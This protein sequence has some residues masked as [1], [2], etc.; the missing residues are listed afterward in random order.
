[1]KSKKIFKLLVITLGI[2]I[3]C[4][5]LA[6]GFFFTDPYKRGQDGLYDLFFRVSNRQD[7]TKTSQA[8]IIAI[9]DNSLIQ[10]FEKNGENWPWPRSY[11][12]L[13]CDYL[14]KDGAK[15][16][17]LDIIYSSPD[18]ERVSGSGVQNDF[19]FYGAMK[20]HNK[21]IIPLNIDNRF[22]KRYSPEY[23]G[24]AELEELLGRMGDD[25]RTSILN[26]YNLEAG[27]GYYELDYNLSQQDKEHIS[28]I[29]KRYNFGP[30]ILEVKGGGELKNVADFRYIHP[31]YSLFTLDNNKFGYV[32]IASEVDG[33]IRNYKPLVRVDESYVPSVALAA[34][35]ISD[36]ERLPDG[37][38][39][40][41]RG[42]FTL[43]WYGPGGINTDESGVIIGKPTFDYYSAWYIFLNARA[44]LRGQE[45]DLPEGT[46]KNR[47]VFIGASAR[48]LL[49]QKNTPF[50]IGGNAY[51]GVEIH[52]TAYLN[53]LN[54]D[55]LK[56]I[57]PTIEFLVYILIVF[58]ITFIGV[59]AKS[60]IRYTIFAFLAFI[61]ILVIQVVSF[62]YLDVVS[63][64]FLYFTFSLLA[65]IATVIAN[66]ITIGQNRNRIR[67]AFGTYV[68]PDILKSITESDE[69]LSTTGKKLEATAL[70]I[71]IA[72]FTT[73]SEK[74]SPERVVEVLNIYL[75]RFSEAIMENKGFIN[76]FLGD[77]LM[78]LF[79]APK[80]IDKHADEA[81]QSALECIRI[82][83]ELNPQYGLDIR[84]GV[85]SGDMI[86]GNMGGT[87]KLE[88][89]AIGDNVNLS[90]RLEGANKFFK[91]KIL[92]GENTHS[93]MTE[94]D[95]VYYLGK[96][97]FKGKDIPIGVYY[98]VNAPKELKEGFEKLIR[99]FEDGDE[100]G[101][102]RMLD[103]FAEKG[104]GFGPA[105]Y[106]RN[107]Y[108]N[109]RDKFGK[110]I[111][112]T[113][114]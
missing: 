45:T 28:E 88:P 15:A 31:P 55:W 8:A 102:I 59:R 5:T 63:H 113:E 20:R 110:P 10:A 22:E 77:G 112:L 89:T 25:E 94:R 40:D 114:K 109:N 24:Q 80:D 72:G 34:Y 106:Y 98:Y 61:V 52:A 32:D 54:R 39:L 96:F 101:F 65:F 87:K 107:Y 3:L 6:I 12:G 99:Y 57:P 18:I 79:S 29:F 70:F 97:S 83:E 30:S 26:S 93:L 7:S 53:L 37:L 85:N 43:N 14:I 60:F 64:I 4:F 1:M 78:A 47:V 38:K 71:D 48:G 23:L 16:V 9:D 46:F 81:I 105:E 90:S 56:H 75:Q 74:N 27:K 17:V 92:L 82:N 35:L 73:F 66:Y 21:V 51:P 68:S 69:P 19:Y 91:T 44:K 33:V 42:N 41:R 104:N 76:K 67:S 111:K 58:V 100:E 50:T 13:I 36:E 11:M 108:N 62:A 86:F 103:F 95:N 84:I 2:T 49:D